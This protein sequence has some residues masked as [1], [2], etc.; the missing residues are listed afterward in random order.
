MSSKWLLRGVVALVLA[1][2]L[3]LGWR[4]VRP[5]QRVGD[6][7]YVPTRIEVVDRMLEL[8][9]VGP[10]D[11]VFDL[12]S[13]DG[14]IVIRAAQ[15]FGA[16]GR[17]FELDPLLVTESRAAAAR[18]G[19]DGR[20]DFVAGN[21]FDAVLGEA[22]AVTLFL[23]PTV[24][25]SLRARLLA[26]LAPGTP[27]VSHMWDMAEW[28]PDEHEVL[29][30]EPTADVFQWIIPAAVGGVWQVAVGTTT[31]DERR[32]A[33]A[34]AP[35]SDVPAQATLRLLQ[36]FQEIEGEL[37]YADIVVPV[38]GRVRGA[39]VSIQTTR[40]HAELGEFSLVGEVTDTRLEG[41]ITRGPGEEA[42]AF[43]ATRRP[44]VIE[45]VW[46]VGAAAEPFVAQWSIEL[47]REGVRWTATRRRADTATSSA[48]DAPLPGVPAAPTEGS[49]EDVYVWGS[50]V[51]FVIGAAD[52]SARRIS[53]Y[54]L[55]EGDRIAGVAHDGGTL[56]PWVGRR[57]V[58]RP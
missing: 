36:R 25:L 26:E 56:V 33:R 45:G 48:V 51:A 38:S 23:L 10:D 49:M 40:P 13:G 5:P 11:L 7:P 4:Q 1:M 44:A 28:I 6:V 34:A 42:T 22:T 9:A 35:G 20:V 15:R 41:D 57:R 30:L 2:M 50:S 39:T 37:R 18:A 16:R 27:V 24:N 46:Q 31:A 55:V 14:R 29:D 53:F 17:G 58:Q 12:G 32:P 3:W 47:Q 8:A 52:G 19:V 21:L 54:G 43:V